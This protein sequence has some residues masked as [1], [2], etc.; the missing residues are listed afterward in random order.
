[1]KERPILF[2]GAMVRAILEGCKTQTRRVVKPQFKRLI[3]QGWNGDKYAIETELLFRGGNQFINSPYGGI[4][5]QLW[6]RETFYIDL[7]PYDRIR[8]PHD[9]PEEM[10]DS[11]IYYRADGECCN[12]ISECDHDNGPAKWRPSIFMPRW[13]SRITLEITDVRVERVQ[14]IIA[15]DAIAEGIFWHEHMEGYA[16]DSEGRNFHAGSP[17]R[18]YEKLW[19]MI[20][21]DRGFGWEANP[22]VWVISFKKNL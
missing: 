17:V 18:S 16:S 2:S 21:F 5:D 15:A 10:D 6:V 4:G 14:D 22:W 12:Q 20:N 11:Y 3:Q 13:A 7:I 19:D 8:L 9:R 1:M